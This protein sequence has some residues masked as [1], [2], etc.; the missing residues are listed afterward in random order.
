MVIRTLDYV[1]Q[2]YTQE[3]GQTIYSVLLPYLEKDT[4][5][6]ISF[7]GVEYVPSSFVNTAFIPLLKKFSFQ[8]IKSCL[9]FV[10]TTKQINEMI[11]DR[12]VFE[13]NHRV[14]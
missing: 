14:Q 1:K 6:E 13:V 8:K 12:F 7:D 9:L 5:V 2:C 11:R 3:D 10:N 4:P